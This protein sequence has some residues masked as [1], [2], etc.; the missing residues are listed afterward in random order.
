M[1]GARPN[2]NLNLVFGKGQ[3]TE[4]PVPPCKIQVG[5]RI[6]EV[7]STPTRRSY[8]RTHKI[9]KPNPECNCKFKTNSFP[10]KCPELNITEN[11][12]SWIRDHL[13][14]Q[15]KKNDWPKTSEALEKRIIKAIKEVNKKKDWFFNAF[16]SLQKQYK[17]RKSLKVN[18]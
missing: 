10:A 17:Q 15:A 9:M 12:F 13:K 11:V 8:T 14:E 6:I 5:E 4:A 1:K 3:W 2:E 16:K 18:Q 7:K